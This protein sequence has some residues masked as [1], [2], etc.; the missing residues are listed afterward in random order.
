MIN[1]AEGD[2]IIHSLLD[3]KRKRSGLAILSSQQLAKVCL[4]PGF[5]TRGAVQRLFIRGAFCHRDGRT[6]GAGVARAVGHRVGHRIDTTIAG[7][8]AFGAQ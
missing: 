6:G 5:D 4:A 2:Y 8:G 1:G 3:Y 7:T